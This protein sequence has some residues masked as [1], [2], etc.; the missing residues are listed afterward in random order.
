MLSTG[1]T[2]VYL[3]LEQRAVQI[4]L[5]NTLDF[6]IPE[7]FK[8]LRESFKTEFLHF[9]HF[10]YDVNFQMLFSTKKKEG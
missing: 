9:H 5:I 10:F 6:C 7:E 8:Q 2:A 1:E 3:L 4:Y